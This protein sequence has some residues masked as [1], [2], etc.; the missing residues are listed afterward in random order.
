[1]FKITPKS[2]FSFWGLIRVNSTE[3]QYYS[4][5]SAAK[6]GSTS[7]LTL[8]VVKDRDIFVGS[9]LAGHACHCQLAEAWRSPW[10]GRPCGA[11]QARRLFRD[12]L[13]TRFWSHVFGEITCAIL[14]SWHQR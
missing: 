13:D 2:R 10:E 6:K 7:R 14:L 4:K 3:Q 12:S 5:L 8:T 9:G 1:M 11:K